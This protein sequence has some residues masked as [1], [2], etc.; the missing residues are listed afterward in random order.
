[1]KRWGWLLVGSGL[2]V[3]VGAVAW[4]HSE[5]ALVSIRTYQPITVDGTLTE[6]VRRLERSNWSGRL[7]VQKGDVLQWIRAVPAHLN[8]LT[9]HVESGKITSPKD[10]SATVYTLWDP[11]NFYVAAIVHDD[12]VVTQHTGQDIWQD[13]ALE[14][15][16]DCRHDA[17]TK[18][19]MQDDE[20]QVGFSPASQYRAEAIAWV[21]RNPNPEPVI[22]AIRVASSR[23]ADG[24]IV[25]ASVPWSALHGCTPEPNQ[26]IGFN[27]SM[28]DKDEDQVWTHLS[29]SGS[30]H[31]DPS[32]FG[33]VYLVDMP[34]DLFP[35]D[36]FEGS[37]KEAPWF[38]GEDSKPEST[39]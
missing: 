35:S 30:L 4:S 13:D 17:V 12:E 26:L 38:Q 28:A 18:T 3:S 29:W 24:Y 33:H 9:S 39:P 2:V 6:W 36:V 25:E 8:A 5:E 20:Y 7:E 1:M 22:K 37:S 32:Q 16:F 21:W 34:L 31:S 15:W 11:T 10:F 27:I 19:L 14:L 23:T